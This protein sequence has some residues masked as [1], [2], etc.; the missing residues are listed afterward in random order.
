M[1]I[2]HTQTIMTT[3]GAIL[4][5]LILASLARRSVSLFVNKTSKILQVNPTNY[6]FLKN[7]SG[8]L[9]FIL[10]L[11]IMTLFVP[12]L[13]S[14]GTG[15]FAGA[16]IFAA[17]IGFASQQAFS[18]IV[19]GIFIV[20]FK[21]FRVGDFIDVNGR[22]GNVEDITLRHTVIRDLENMRIIIPNASISA[23]TIVNKHIVDERI[24]RRMAYRI[25]L[26]ADIEKAMAILME[27]IKNHPNYIDGRTEEDIK[28]GVP[29]LLIRVSEIGE[30]F[31]TLLVY[32]WS[33]DPPS[34]F[35]LYCD[36]NVQVLKRFKEEGIEIP[37]PHRK[38]ISKK[39]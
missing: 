20:I 30:Y 17:I 9:V 21:P 33:V 39:D 23:E 37:V 28:K 34:S 31:I 4:L 16:G 36:V 22:G 7:G 27:V 18:N 1:E 6:V 12:A 32:A 24:R 15:V 29:E 13:K 35:A 25:A 3:L 10:T 8:L 14:I 11:L 2:N 19:G 26:D 5:A 38:I